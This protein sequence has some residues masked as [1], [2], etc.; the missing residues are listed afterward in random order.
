MRLLR[1]QAFYSLKH[2]WPRHNNGLRE[3]LVGAIVA[4]LATS[5]S[6]AGVLKKMR[7]KSWILRRFRAEILE[8]Y[9][10]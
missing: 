9:P 10:S 7:R 2:R 1:A 6:R 5:E 4:I 3:S 8:P